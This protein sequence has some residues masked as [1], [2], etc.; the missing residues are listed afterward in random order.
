MDNCKG[1]RY[2]KNK[3]KRMMLSGR[4]RKSEVKI[5]KAKCENP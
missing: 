2:K 1:N 5:L 3:N 4:I